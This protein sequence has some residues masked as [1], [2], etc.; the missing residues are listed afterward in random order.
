MKRSELKSLIKEAIEEAAIETGKF[1]VMK[2][3]KSEG[4]A[5]RGI[6]RLIG[7]GWVE[8]SYHNIEEEAKTA[9]NKLKKT[10]NIHKHRI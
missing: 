4:G 1:A 6:P 10:T 9:I 8:V 3:S 7:K 2:L 5:P